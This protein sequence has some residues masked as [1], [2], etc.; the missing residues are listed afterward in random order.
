MEGSW[1]WIWQKCSTGT[2]IAATWETPRVKGKKPQPRKKEFEAWSGR[3]RVVP[4]SQIPL[5]GEGLILL[6][7]KYMLAKL[8]GV[9]KKGGVVFLGCNWG[10]AR[11]GSLL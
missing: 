3:N 1:F 4:A 6:Q 10:V 9:N 7:G 8:N 2:S 11:K 5:L